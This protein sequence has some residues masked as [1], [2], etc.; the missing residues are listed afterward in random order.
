MIVQVKLFA[1]AKQIVDSDTF[2][3]EATEPIRVGEIRKRLL[4]AYPQFENVLPHSRF[5]VNAAYVNDDTVVSDTD[6]VA[7]IPPVSGG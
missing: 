6:E 2:D 7:I 5:A 4:S 3:V 1:V